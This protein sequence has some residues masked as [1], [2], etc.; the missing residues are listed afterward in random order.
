MTPLRL[1]V[2]C[3]QLP[4]HRV[5]LLPLCGDVPQFC[6]APGR[7]TTI[8]SIEREPFTTPCLVALDYL[9]RCVSNEDSEIEHQ[10]GRW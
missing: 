3:L 2:V 1:R 8:Q 9:K 10:D 6:T 5:Q 4:R 7:M